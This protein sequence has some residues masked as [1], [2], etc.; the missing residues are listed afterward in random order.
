MQSFD[1]DYAVLTGNY[2]KLTIPVGHRKVVRAE[3]I[4]AGF[5][6]EPDGA[7]WNQSF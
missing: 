7:L 5:E 1:P 6:E 2:K 3:E 4:L